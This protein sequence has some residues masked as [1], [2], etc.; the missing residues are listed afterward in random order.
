MLHLDAY[1]DDY[2]IP[3]YVQGVSYS[4]L[5]RRMPSVD[6]LLLGHIH[7]QF[8]PFAYTNP[9]TGKIQMVSKPAAFGRVVK[10]Y[11]KI[12]EDVKERGQIP[13]YAMIE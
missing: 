10:E 5:L 12:E 8:E 6:L 3:P 7:Y 9:D 4:E 11:F 2:K 1:P 13:S